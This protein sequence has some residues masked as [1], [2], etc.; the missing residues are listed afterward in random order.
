MT[1][2]KRQAAWNLTRAEDRDAEISVTALGW[3]IGSLPWQFQSARQR[4]AW[5]ASIGLDWNDQYDLRQATIA[6]WRA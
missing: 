4:I 3:T 1:A 2:K 6:E 5:L